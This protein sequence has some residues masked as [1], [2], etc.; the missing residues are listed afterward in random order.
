M[1]KKI[2][3]AHLK[4]QEEISKLPPDQQKVI[5]E[6]QRL[7]NFAM[8][9]I[10]ETQFD[11]VVDRFLSIHRILGSDRK[12]FYNCYRAT[13]EGKTFIFR[14]YEGSVSF[15]KT[16]DEK[17]MSA[18]DY[19]YLLEHSVLV[20]NQLAREKIFTSCTTWSI[21]KLFVRLLKKKITGGFNG[22]KETEKTNS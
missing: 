20:T 3:N 6:E 12:D 15:Y 7:V 1:T 19:I 13:K 10:N 16:V 5:K 18:D 14:T 8:K 11:F 17:V 22:S 21:I 9:E 4:V 2:R